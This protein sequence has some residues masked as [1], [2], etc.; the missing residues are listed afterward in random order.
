MAVQPGFRLSVE[1]H[2]CLI[3]GTLRLVIR[4]AGLVFF[5]KLRSKIIRRVTEDLSIL[6]IGEC[7]QSDCL[8]TI[9]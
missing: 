5:F 2:C 4:C 6:T 3:P 9:Y 1:A 7:L 8:I